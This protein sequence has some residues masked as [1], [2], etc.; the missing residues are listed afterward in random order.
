MNAYTKMVLIS[1]DE[2]YKLKSVTRDK[3]SHVLDR[4]L[5]PQMIE[6]QIN[7]KLDD[8]YRQSIIQPITHI[9]PEF[10]TSQEKFDDFESADYI[11]DDPAVMSVTPK[12]DKLK[13]LQHKYTPRG[14]IINSEKKVIRGSNVNKVMDFLT[15]STP[16]DKPGPSG[17]KTIAREL[18][19]I[20]EDDVVVNPKGKASIDMM[21]AFN[22]SLERIDKSRKL[23]NDR[24]NLQEGKGWSSIKRF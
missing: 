21:A 7:R 18:Y 2:Y 13:K 11:W 19:R 8:N 9:T 22:E 15:S 16:I 4:P 5:P 6:N 12:Q 23:Y 17:Y 14:R 3:V 20:G 24:W 1:E 10:D